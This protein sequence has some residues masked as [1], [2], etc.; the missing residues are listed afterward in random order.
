MRV[1]PFHQK[2]REGGG[3]L[4][5]GRGTSFKGESDHAGVSKLFIPISNK[6]RQEERLWQQV[7][8]AQLLS[9]KVPRNPHEQIVTKNL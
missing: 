5:G 7:L 2:I 4:G 1:D 9:G 6:E 8:S 3:G